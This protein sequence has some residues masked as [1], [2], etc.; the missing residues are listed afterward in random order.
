MKGGSPQTTAPRRAD[1]QQCTKQSF[2]EL[3][4]LVDVYSVLPRQ[5]LVITLEERGAGGFQL[6]ALDNIYLI[7]LAV[8]THAP[9]WYVK[10]R[11]M[12]FRERPAEAN[13]NP[14]PLMVDIPV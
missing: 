14:R 7:A 5:A 12:R 8:H 1:L 6:E 3:L 9:G 10:Q 2:E 4:A 11:S 13:P